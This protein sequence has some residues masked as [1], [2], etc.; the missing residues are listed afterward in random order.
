M[1]FRV[2]EPSEKS[3]YKAKSPGALERWT[4]ASCLSSVCH[5]SL[6]AYSMSV[7]NDVRSSTTSS[8]H[9]YLARLEPPP[10]ASA[11]RFVES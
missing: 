4:L 8:A 6:V 5:F 11:L 7:K 9:R 10:S 3:R 2:D 1:P